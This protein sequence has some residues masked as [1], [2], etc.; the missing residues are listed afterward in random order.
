MLSQLD[1]RYL[2]AAQRYQR[3]IAQRNQ[4]LKAIAERRAKP[5][6]LEFWSGQAAETGGY[7]M[8][9]RAKTVAALS[10]LAEELYGSMSGAGERCELVYAPS[11]ST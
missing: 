4:V 11:V 3:V 7:M 1:R 10:P 6:E 8:A 2:R 9:G 5:D